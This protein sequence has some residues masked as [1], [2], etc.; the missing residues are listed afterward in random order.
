VCE[1]LAHD[2]YM[3]VP[4]LVLEPTNDSAWAGTQTHHLST[5]N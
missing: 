2:C 1:L 4:Q 5:P 3:I